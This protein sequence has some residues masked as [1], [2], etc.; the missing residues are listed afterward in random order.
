MCSHIFYMTRDPKTSYTVVKQCKVYIITHNI[1]PPTTCTT[2]YKQ[3]TKHAYIVQTRINF[4]Y[5][6]WLCPRGQACWLE[7][8]RKP[9]KIPG[10]SICLCP[11][12]L[13]LGDLSMIQATQDYITA[14]VVL[15][16]MSDV[17]T[18]CLLLSN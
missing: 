4:N 9:A 13:L 6:F 15:S 17:L 3:T 10:P 16:K 14:T 8:R 5:I 7:I 1:S 12:I 18:S 11:S 2:W